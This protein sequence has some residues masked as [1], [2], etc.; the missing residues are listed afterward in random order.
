MKKIKRLVAV[1]LA[2][3]M[4][5]GSFSTVAFAAN[6]TDGNGTTLSISTKIFRLVNGAWVETEK[7][8][9]GEQVMARV[10]VDTDYYTNSGSLLFFYNNTFFTDSFGTLQEQLDINTDYKGGDYGISGHFVGSKSAST[11]EKLMLNAGKIDSAFAAENDFIFVNY[12]FGSNYKNQK[13]DGSKWLFQVPLTVTDA[14]VAEKGIF[15]AIEATT[16]SADFPMGQIN[17]PRGE[18]DGFNSTNEAMDLWKAT[19]NYENQPVELYKTPV[20]VT[21]DAKSGKFANG[22]LTKYFE[23]DAGDELVIDEPSR[24]NFKFVGWKESGADD[25]TASKVVAYPAQDTTYEAVWESTTGS[26]EVLGFRTEIYRQNENGEWIKTDRVKRGEEV[27]ARV[28]IDTSYYTHAGDVMFFYDKDFFEDTLTENKNNSLKV[29]PNETAAHGTYGWFVKVPATSVAVTRQVNEGYIPQSLV[30]ESIIYTMNYQF[31]P[32][33]GNVLSGDEWFAEFDLKVRADA[34]GG[35]YGDFYISENTLQNSTDR[36]KAYVNIPLSS[37]G[38]KLIDAK[39]MYLWNVNADVS[40]NP[41]TIDSKVTLDAN[42]GFFADGTNKKII[43]GFVGDPIDAGTIPAVEKDGAVFLGWVDASIAEPTEADVVEI[44]SA[45]PH[46]DLEL[47]ALWLE[48]INVT[49][50]IGYGA[51]DIIESVVPGS[52][53][54]AP[55]DPAN[56]DYTFVG[57]STDMTG[58]TVTGLPA[59]Y[60]DVNTTYYAIWVDKAEITYKF[61]NGDEDLVEKVTAGDPL[62]APADPAKEGYKFIGWSTDEKGATITGLPATYP[63]EDTV[64]HAI[65]NPAEFTINYYVINAETGRFELVDERSVTYG[66]PVVATIPSYEAP[67]GYTLSDAYTDITL[68]TPLAADATMPAGVLNLYYDLEA[69]EYEAVFMV[70]GEE[71]EKVTTVFGEQIKAPTEPTKEGYVFK[72]W[73]NEVGLMVTEGAIFNATWEKAEYTAT[74]IVDGATYEE[75]DIAFGD[76]VDV[77]ADPYK[78]GYE[79]IGWTPAIPAV[80]PAENQEFIAVFEVNVHKATFNANTGVYADD[81]TSKE[82]NVNYGDAV[83]APEEPTKTGY[84]FIGWDPALPEAMPDEDL[85]FNAK[86]EPKKD[87]KYTIEYHTM[88][89]D[90]KYGTPVVENR[91]GETDSEVSVTPNPTDGFKVADDSVIKATIAAD[92]STKL[93]VKYEREQYT[94]KFDPAN[95]EA[96][97][98]QKYYYG[99]TVTAPTAP[100]KEGH[101]FVEWKP[102]VFGTVTTDVTYVAQYDANEYTITFG[103]TGDTVIDPIKQDFG[104]DI[105]K[106]ADPTKEGYTFAGWDKE[107]PATMPAENVTVNATWTINQYTISFEDTGDTT[108]NDITL[109]YGTD[110]P[111]VAAPTKTG[112]T[113]AGWDKQ[114]PAKMPAEDTVITALWDVNEYTITFGNTGDTVIDPIKQDFGTDIVKPA[115]PE[116][117][118]YTFDGWD[119]EIPATMP[120]ENSTINAT[121]KINSY[122]A[123]FYEK[124]DSAEPYRTTTVEYLK[125]INAVPSPSKTGYDFAGWSADG[126]NVLTDLGNMDTEGKNFY[127]VWTPASVNYKVEHYYMTVD[128]AYPEAA[129]STENFSAKTESVVTTAGKTEENFTVDKD[130]SVLE[131]TVAADGSTV[132]KVYY[133]R[134]KNNLRVIVDGEVTDKEYFFEAPVDAIAAPTK[135]GYTFAGWV[136]ENNAATS[137]PSTMPADDVTVKATWTADEYEVTYFVG[138]N[139]YYGPTVT[140]YGTPIAEPGVPTKAGYTFKGWEDADGKKPADYGVMPDKN[141]EFTAKF[142][143]DTGVTY[144]VEIYEMGTNGQYPATATETNILTDG[145]VGQK[146]T[147]TPDDRAGFVFDAGASL[148]SGTV[149]PTGVLTLKLYYTRNSNTLTV[150][151]DGKTT[152]KDYYYGQAIED[153]EVPEKEGYT[154]EGWTTDIPATMPDNDVTTEAV[155]AKNS[156]KV[157]WDVDGDKDEATVLYGDAITEPAAPTKPGYEFAGWTPEV[158]ENMPAKDLTFVATWKANAHTAT[159]D[160]DGGVYADGTGSK[161]VPV[162]FGEVIIAPTAPT[163]TGFAFAGWTPAVPATMPDEDLVFTATWAPVSGTVYTVEYYT[164]GTDGKYGDPVVEKRSGATGAEATATINLTDGFKVADDSVIKATIAADGSTKL[165]VKYEREQYTVKFDPANGE[166]VTEQKYYYGATVT[167]PTAPEKEGHTFVE[168]KPLVFGTVTTDVTYVAQYDANEYTITF[169]DTGD[170]VIDPIKQDFGTDIVKPADPTKEGYTFAGWDKEIP[171]TMPAENVTVNATWTI[172]QYTISFEDTGDT[173]INDITL[174]YGTDVPAVAAPE[175]KGYTFAGWDKEIPAK[176]PA[177]DTVITALWDVNEYT[178]TFGNTGDTVIDP[179]KQDFGTDIVKPED[180]TKT[181]YTF[182]GWDAEIP[183][184]MPA[185]NVTVN[186]KWKVNQ[187]TISFENTGDTTIADI[188]LDYG[189][190]IPTV[191]TPDKEGYTWNGWDKEIPANMPAEDTVITGQWTVNQYTITFGNTGDTVIDPITQDYGTAVTAPADPTRFG[192]NF[193]GWTAEIPA[194]MPATDTIINAKWKANTYVAEFYAELDDT[195]P[196]DNPSVAFNE[197]IDAPMDN[198]S[199]DGYEFIAWSTDGKTPIYDLGKMDAEG[200]KFYA[201]WEATDVDYTVEHYYMT[202]DLTYA[203]AADKTEKLKAET[204]TTV[205]ATPE[206]TENFT[207]DDDNSVLE[208]TVA[209][210]GSTVLKVYYIREVNTLRVNIDGKV[211]DKEYPFDAPVDAITEPTKEGYTFDGWVDDEGNKVD[212]PATMPGEDVSLNATWDAIAYE[213]TYIVDGNTYYGP[214]SVDFGT[215]IG[216]PTVPTKLGHT[217]AGWKDADGKAPADYGVMPA[218]NL[219]FTAQWNANTDI[220]YVI[221]IYEM[222]TEGNYPAS[223]TDKYTLNDGVVGETRTVTPDVRDGFVLDTEKSVL[224][225]TIPAEG[226]LVLKAYYIRNAHKLIVDVDGTVTEIPYKFGAEVAPVTEPTKTGYTFAGWEDENGEEADVPVVMPDKDVT[227]VATWDIVKYDAVFNAGDGKFSDGKN[228]ATVPVDYNTAITAPAEMPALKGY[229]FGG[230]ATKADPETPVTDYGTMDENGAEFVAI[231]NK[232]SYNLTFI[233]Y[234]VP[235]SNP[236]V[237]SISNRKTLTE[238]GKKEYNEEITLP[239][240]PD[241]VHHVFLGWSTVEFDANFI[242]EDGLKM[243]ASD[244]TLYAVYERVQVMLIPKNETCTTVIDRNDLTVDDYVDGESKWYVYGLEQMITTPELL[245]EYID[246]SGDGR[247]ELAFEATQNEGYPGTGTTI[248]VYDNVDNELVES[249]KIIIFGDLNGDAYIN[250]V[251]VAIATDESLGVTGW[252]ATNNPDLYIEHRYLAADVNEDGRINAVDVTIISDNSLGVY[253]IDQRLLAD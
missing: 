10:Y 203:D 88:G 246:V 92:G 223:A 248:N 173:T 152:T 209:G 34:P 211:T 220:G 87:T 141:L 225:G 221:E 125:E 74:Y 98:E 253:V 188:T 46:D 239:A 249:F 7:V 184:T 43:E 186:A 81:S 37:E 85:V 50:V 119:A 72:G 40:S 77:P 55:E 218:K 111:A 118:G 238:S 52:T 68:T 165:V 99:A 56:D 213:V 14:P 23:G 204:A 185:E 4:I 244:L 189:A 251:D 233:G 200:K 171:A 82:I 106:P 32:S 187:Y 33:T 127:A 190:V 229:E 178:I 192:Y 210:D 148:V 241:F 80:M 126:E 69:K 155:Y 113:F 124:L 130:A 109:D 59:V 146:V 6:E 70:D 212:Y 45:I 54:V 247:I 131:A 65:Y 108:I 226:T 198:P 156:Y 222:D 91:T 24:S 101:T 197:Y 17:V 60:P 83:V 161:D 49:Y 114:I 121:W 78:E 231:W 36:T 61:N 129:D 95:G 133:I 176:M 202:T 163:K 236:K 180:P 112:Y 16:L 9:A 25:S 20:S 194:T 31:N 242:V 191:A 128:G 29:N 93:V 158:P 94:V 115:D 144:V 235:E 145:V 26:S 205:T 206:T 139:I 196:F 237:P 102:L 117:F 122:E 182:D 207:L 64:Y 44:P 181:G 3:L 35:E 215:P 13:L 179:I 73:D 232:V 250:A 63:S 5:L 214:K 159:F 76:E 90:G 252:S 39:A 58:A 208:A 143:A 151:I 136:D 201:V 142:E 18:E 177:E 234:N 166:A 164:M 62:V 170:T 48:K 53:L 8:K 15:Q 97:T 174:D 123:K 116:K 12:F 175:K 41:V 103:D 230:W 57:W 195:V 79:F 100:E 216:E 154:F 51:A 47:K 120:A 86:W 169:G 217:F 1:A 28:F 134:E 2:L 149:P 107:I 67:V 193:E 240:G 243:P 21:F 38:G 160:A 227:L 110:V 219:E 27:K 11:V 84:E 66:D 224:T 147:V 199:K 228:E 167:A 138:D 153:I 137:V 22:D 132:L 89:T 157:T 183:S 30:D 245:D 162:N 150:T 104:T 96:V 19:L 140:A 105:V 135:T 71:Y 75:Y 42:G 168:W 172:N